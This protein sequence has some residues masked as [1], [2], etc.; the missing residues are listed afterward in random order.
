[1][2]RIRGPQSTD[3]YLSFLSKYLLVAI[4]TTTDSGKLQEGVCCGQDPSVGT[5][6]A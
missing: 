6:K 1:M 4:G 5:L 2:K 3:I